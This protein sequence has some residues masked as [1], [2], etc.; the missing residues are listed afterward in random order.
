MGGKGVGGELAG[1]WRVGGKGSWGISPVSVLLGCGSGRG[2]TSLRPQT[3]PMD[4]L[5]WQ[6]LSLASRNVASSLVI[7]MIPEIDFLFLLDP[8]VGGN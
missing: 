1:D 4:A 8:E 5:P 2:C 7:Q 3:L 6:Q